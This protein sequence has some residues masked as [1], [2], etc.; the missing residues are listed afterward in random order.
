MGEQVKMLKYH[1]D[2]GSQLVDIVFLVPDPPPLD[3]D[4]TFVCDLEE[5]QTP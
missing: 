5:V 4:L 1:T 3:I 2:S